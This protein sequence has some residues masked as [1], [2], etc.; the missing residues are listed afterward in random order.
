MNAE[1]CIAQSSVFRKSAPI[2][3]PKNED[4]SEYSLK[5]SEFDP[6]KSSPPNSWNTRLLKRLSINNLHRLQSK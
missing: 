2:Q 5:K 4:F 1:V 6:T 3:I